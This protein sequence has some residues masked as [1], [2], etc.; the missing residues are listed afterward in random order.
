MSQNDIISRR[1][2]LQDLRTINKDPIPCVN[3]VP[4]DKNMLI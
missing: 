1:R 4:N 3:T 2:L